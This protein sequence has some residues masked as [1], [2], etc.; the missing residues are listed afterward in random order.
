MEWR[1][2][3]THA[4]A[5]QSHGAIVGTHSSGSSSSRGLIKTRAHLAQ[6][7][8]MEEENTA[9]LQG[10]NTSLFGLAGG[11]EVAVEV[12]LDNTFEVAREDDAVPALG[13]DGLEALDV[14][15]GRD[16]QVVLDV[17]PVAW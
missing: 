7:T 13:V 4:C 3:T 15:V 8:S 16:L 6:D 17:E 12:E 9:R 10:V 5:Y 14:A 1:D 11:A 2:K